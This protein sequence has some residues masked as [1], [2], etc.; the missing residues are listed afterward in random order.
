MALYRCKC[1]K[2]R[3]LPKPVEEY[4]YKPKCKACGLLLHYRD[5]WQERKNLETTCNCGNPHYPHR[6]GSHIFCIHSNNEPSNEDYAHYY[7][8]AH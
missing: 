5:K 2:R 7:G 3:A 4:I 6:E 1:G 8:V